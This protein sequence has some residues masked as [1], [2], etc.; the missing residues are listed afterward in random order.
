M[1]LLARPKS[2]T[3]GKPV[4]RGYGISSMIGTGGDGG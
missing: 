3:A 1:G 2:K 4:L